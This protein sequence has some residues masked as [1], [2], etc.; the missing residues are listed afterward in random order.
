MI[1]MLNKTNCVHPAPWNKTVSGAHFRSCKTYGHAEGLS[2]CFRQWRAEHSH[3]RF[4]HGYALAF[5]FTFIASEL[6]QHNWCMD[7]G[8]L[9]PVRQWLHDTFDHKLI[10]A[11]DD[12]ELA[13]FQALEKAGLCQLQIMP[14]TG[15]EAFAYYAC[16]HVDDMVQHMTNSRVRVES[17]CVHEHAGNSA[18]YFNQIAGT[19][20]VRAAGPCAPQEV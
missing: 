15:C 3:C 1:A 12:P 11:K 4:L 18:Q 13:S 8:N 20:A 17:V 2:C 19:Q 7:F 16:C 6:D 14:A 10:I 5:T 9:K